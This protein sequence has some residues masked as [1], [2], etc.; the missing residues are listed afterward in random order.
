MN[1]LTMADCLKMLADASALPEGWCGDAALT[2]TEEAVCSAKALL[3]TFPEG[4]LPLIGPL[5]DGALQ[6]EWHYVDHVLISRVLP[7]G[8]V[9]GPRT[10][11]FSNCR[12]AEPCAAAI[13]T[14]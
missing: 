11:Y 13:V 8:T 1:T 3:A 7:D 9:T 6:L 12:T 14:P 4:S 5:T 10:V 2:P